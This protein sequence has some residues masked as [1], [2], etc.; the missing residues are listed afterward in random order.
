MEKRAFNG[1]DD[2]SL[3]ESLQRGDIQAFNHLFGK[4][5]KRLYSFGIKYLRTKEDAEGLVQGV[6]MRVWE[7]R[8][9]LKKEASF[10]SFLFTIAYNEICSV[11]R[12]RVTKREHR[13]KLAVELTGVH[14]KIDDQIEYKSV[15]EEVDR[16]IAQLPEKQREVLLFRR[17]MGLSSKEIARELNLTPGTVDNYIS[18][19][20]KFIRSQLIRDDLALLL[21]LSC[22]FFR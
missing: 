7:N 3:V 2:K 14:L 9:N 21:I 4:Y 11:F 19:A 18:A 16:L 1:I 5:A 8:E 22:C 20:I 17:N 13:E 12:K 10:K 15:L 6:F